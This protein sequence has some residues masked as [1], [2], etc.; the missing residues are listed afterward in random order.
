MAQIHGKDLAISLDAKDLGQYAKKVDFEQEADTHDTTTF[1][2][3]SKVYK[4][5]LK[6][7]TATIEGIYDSTAVTG[8]AAVIRPLLGTT[9]EM[10][11][12]P[13]G[14]GVGKPI[15]TV[16]VVVTA[17]KESTPVDDMITWTCDL[18]LSDDVV[19]T[20]GEA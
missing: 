8:P 10:V 20:V 15:H 5:G 9:V 11:Y 19:T 7:G 4:G 12:K 18:Q 16:D 6:D 14:S 17:Y 13:E 1:G 3:G 2:K